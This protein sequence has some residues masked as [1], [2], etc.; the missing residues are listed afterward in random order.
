MKPG[1]DGEVRGEGL[2]VDG[3]RIGLMAGG[4]LGRVTGGAVGRI[5]EEGSCEEEFPLG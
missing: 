3:G 5:P 2:T 1:V 4:T